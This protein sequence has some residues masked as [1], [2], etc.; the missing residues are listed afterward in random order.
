M[1]AAIAEQIQPGDGEIDQGSKP[2]D[3]REDVQAA[4]RGG[5]NGLCTTYDGVIGFWS[6]SSLVAQ[7]KVVSGFSVDPVKMSAN[8]L[9]DYTLRPALEGRQ[10]LRTADRLRLLDPRPI[11][12]Y[13]S[14]R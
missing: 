13:P 12:L 14:P 4:A 9:I 2:I 10:P 3:R 1:H 7:Q 8:E 11:G 6:V 5:G